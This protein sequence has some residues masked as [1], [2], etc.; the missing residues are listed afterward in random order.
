MKC[1]A[2]Q[3]TSRSVLDWMKGLTAIYLVSSP[4][5]S[6]DWR[7]LYDRARP[8]ISVVRSPFVAPVVGPIL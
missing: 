5:R 7:E 3:N 1:P 4:L 6:A 2:C 8:G